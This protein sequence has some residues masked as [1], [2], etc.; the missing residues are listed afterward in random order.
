MSR[1]LTLLFAVAGGTAVG[2][3][4]WAQPLL[5]NIA[6]SLGV[7][8]GVAGLL[9]TVTQ[10]GYATGILLVVPL[11]D[12]V[13]RRRL[14]P[15]MMVCSALAL[16]A[17]ALAPTF[18]AL[19]VTLTAVGLTT[20]TGQLLIPLAGDLARDD[21]RGQVVGTVASGVLTGI[22]VSR[23]ISGVLADAFGWRAIYLAAAVATGVVAVVLSRAL[24]P[25][26]PRPTVPYVKLLGSV[27]TAVREHRAVQVTLVLGASVFSVFTLFWTGL[28]FLLSA[29]PFSYSVTKIGLVGLAGLAGALAAQRAGRLHDR[30]WSVPATGAAL[31]LALLSLAIA[32]LGSTSIFAVLVAVVLIDVAIQAVNVLN[33][34][35]L[36]SLDANARSRL[37]TAF[38]TCNFIGGAIG[39]ALAAI[40]WQLGGWLSVTLAGSL[41]IGFALIVWL[42]QRERALAVA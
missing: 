9:V 10:V 11:G 20:I 18:V 7:P 1:G 29:P 4:Y 16:T 40:L 36:F 37:N 34:T 28:T 41:L 23:T 13:N 33:Q 2:N 22:L 32:A 14:I 8:T 17:S 30:G 24:P 38:V 42:T 25:V 26:P 12:T 3:L 21:Q 6:D 5:G 35:R 15:A 19:L 31:T 39:S 27:F